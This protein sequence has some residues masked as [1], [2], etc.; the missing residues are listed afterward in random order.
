[1]ERLHKIM[2]KAGVASR[3]RSE[4]LILRGHV[5]VDGKIVREMGLRVDPSVNKIKVFGRTLDI[6]APKEYIMINKPEGYLTTVR[7]PYNRPT[8]MQ[9]V[10]G[11]EYGLFP[12]G[13]LDQKTTGLLILTND[14]ELAYRLTHP[15]YKVAKIYEAEVRGRP[16]PS[17]IWR[18]RNG[19]ILE[20]GPTQPARVRIALRKE[21][22]TLLEITIFEGRK[23]QIRRMCQAIGNPVVKL[24][25]IAIGPVTLGDLNSGSWRHMTQKEVAHLKDSTDL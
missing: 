17:S 16:K 3:R 13:R 6:S 22:T 24:N 25:R 1:M 9:L 14:G 18:L 7:D 21:K 12:I 20:D 19:V 4:E 15:R 23:R 2:A 11:P 5:E 8:V 10:G